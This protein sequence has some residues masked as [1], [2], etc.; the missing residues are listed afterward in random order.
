[1]IVGPGRPGPGQRSDDSIKTSRSLL[2][3]SVVGKPKVTRGY[4]LHQIQGYWGQGLS[5]F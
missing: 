1:M 5:G 4:D 2:V 3:A